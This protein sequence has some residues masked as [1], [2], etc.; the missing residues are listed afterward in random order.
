MKHA[1]YNAVS[2]E[3]ALFARDTVRFM[4]RLSN[5]HGI[6]HLMRGLNVC[7]ELAAMGAAGRI[8][9]FGR[10]APP[11]QLWDRR[12]EFRTEGETAGYRD[13][14]QAMRSANP[15]VVVYDTTLPADDEWRREPEG[16]QR[17]YIMRRWK[18]ERQQELLDH[19]LLPRIDAVIVPHTPEE[20][21]HELP[22]W[23]RKRVSFVGPIVRLPD[24]LSQEKLR[25]RYALT[26]A[27]FVLTSTCGGGGFSTQAKEFFATVWAVHR[28]LASERP[29]LRHIVVLGPNGCETPVPAPGMTLVDTEPDMVSLFAISDLV[30]AEGGYNTVNEIR[31]TRTPALFMPG[32]RNLDDQEH[33]VRQLE[34]RGLAWVCAASERHLAPAKA[35]ALC[36]DSDALDAMR[37]AYA[38]DSPGIGN[39]RAAEILAELAA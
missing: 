17:A 18:D 10:A 13:W 28:R 27:D 12:F 24:P 30:I 38:S 37:R 20:F 21:G 35:L 2:R 39:R 8:L 16:A 1:A 15:A 22:A 9:F 19:G 4:L 26:P 7:R 33:R 34:A 6:G 23:L 29:N 31:V 14:P 25:R 5:R 36:R 3:E 11:R 32:T